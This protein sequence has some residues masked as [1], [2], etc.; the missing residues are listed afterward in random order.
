MLD[1]EW[2][3]VPIENVLDALIDYRGKT[4]QKS[5][6]GIPTL[7][8]KSVKMNFIDYSQ[9]YYISESEY[10]K[11][12]VRGFPQKGDILLTTEAPLGV[13]ARLNRDDVALGQRLITLRGKKGILDNGYLLYYLQ[14]PH[15][16][17]KLKSRESGTTVTG[18]KQ[19]EFRKLVIPL[20][21]FSVQQKIAKILSALD[22]K[23]E[24][25][26][27]INRNLEEQAQ[28]LFKNWFVDFEPFD[29]KMPDDWE[30]SR[31]GDLPIYVTDYVSNGSFASLKENVALSQDDGFAYFVRNTDLKVGTFNT[32]VDEHSY[33]FLEKSR[34]FGGEIIISN[35][36]DVGSVFL[37]PIL[38]RPMTLGN[39][40]IM[41]R[42][43]NPCHRNFFYMWFNWFDG[44]TLIKNITGGSVLQKF[45]KTDF[46]NLK[47]GMPTNRVLQKFAKIIDPYFEHISEIKKENQRLATIRE[48]ILP[49]LMSGELDVV[50]VRL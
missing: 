26:N 46:K 42:C 10:K 1:M 23:I 12:M 4:P 31:I 22:D 41:L 32:F 25:N 9:C 2:K 15:G 47:I 28:A 40:I 34:L 16:Q 36:G 29:R 44:Q 14:S 30:N 45:N 38:D 3:E 5:V 8:A 17:Y 50:E 21:P 13:V 18:I 6:N 37:C 49:K 20:P 7:S 35:V 33:K 11:F 39:N 43:E 48:T 27:A 24:L 19:A